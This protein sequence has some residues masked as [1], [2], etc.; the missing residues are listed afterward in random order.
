MELDD[1]QRHADAIIESAAALSSAE[2]AD[3]IKRYVAPNYGLLTDDPVVRA[4][5]PWLYT[6]DGR[7]IFDGVAAYSAANLGHGHPLIR[8]VLKRFLDSGAPTVLGRFLGDPYLALFGKK[9]VEMSGFER[10]LPAN[11]GVEG[12]EAAIKLARRWAHKVKGV[13]GVPEILY[14]VGCFHGRT[15]TVT[16]MFGEDE[17]EARDGFGPWTP[18]FRRIAFND[19]SAVADAITPD[20]AALLIEPIQGEG[21]INVPDEGYLTEVV[22]VCRDKNVLVIFDEVQ[23]G[24]ART[25]KMFCWMHEGDAA[26]PDIMAIGKSVSGGYAPIAGILADNNL[27]ELMGPGS[28]G[29]TFGGCPISSAIGVAAL[30]AIEQENL[31]QQAAEKGPRVMAKLREIAERS[32]RIAQIR[33]KGMM[34]G[35]EV[36]REEPDAD[37]YSKKLLKLGAILKS[38]HRWVLRFTP[39]IVS[40]NDDLD[41]VLSL[42][43]TAFRD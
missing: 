22:K 38:T 13:T 19:V 37:A 17:P 4:E 27:M 34:F 42:I 25:G 21:G 6:K 28:H 24:W 26:R 31:V 2:A 16:Q 30:E 18:G 33:G 32:P 15:T 14:A 29:S 43:D 36:T 39:P 23:T 10:F 35:I 11:G 3:L 8:E 9:A 20:T 1:V 12:P 5:G 7:K 41:H 40:S